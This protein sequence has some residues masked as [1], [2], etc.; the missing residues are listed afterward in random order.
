MSS[1]DY[2]WEFITHQE[3]LKKLGLRTPILEE[4]QL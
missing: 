4:S 3:A 1:F 2:F